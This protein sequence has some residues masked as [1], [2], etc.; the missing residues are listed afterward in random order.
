V[1]LLCSTIG[2]TSQAPVLAIARVSLV[3]VISGKIDAGMTVVV[4]GDTISAIGRGLAPP[5]GA[6]IVDGAGK[7]LIPGLWDMHVHNEAAGLESVGLFVANGVTGARDMGS[8]L[9]F[10]LKLRADIASGA[11]VGPTLVV[12][13][14]ILDNA[15]EGWP[16]R[17]RIR[18]ADEGRDA[19]RML[20]KRG[21]DF[22][23]VHDRTPRDAYLAI[24]REARAQ[25]LPVDGHVPGGVTL[26]EAEDE[27]QRTIEHLANFRVFTECSDGR[28][29]RPDACRAVFKRIAQSR[30]WQTPTQAFWRAILTDGT[31]PGDA[32]AL[33]LSYASPKLRE[34]W[35]GN[36]RVSEITPEK[37]RILKELSHESQRAVRDLKDAGVG[38][39]AGSDGLVPG[40]SLH[41]ELA[42]FVGSGLTPLEAL[43]TA[44]INPARA[45]GQETRRGSVAVGKAADLVLLDANPLT[46]IANTRR[47]DGVVLRGRHFARRE[48]DTM[49]AEIRTRFSGR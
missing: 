4:T 35:A 48:L 7:Y 28:T 31:A 22:I 29:Y 3:D 27:G 16:F 39:L 32:E 40:F 46:D 15:P 11:V 6:R 19:V 24:G 30:V 23:K 38:L 26:R 12:A 1:A 5:R 21:V 13:G 41:D 17:M 25:G 49:L 36:R 43:Q 20:K 14:P 33:H 45:L 34:I 44:T 10:I 8:E 37:T 42:E 2:A 9:E 18:T 47:I